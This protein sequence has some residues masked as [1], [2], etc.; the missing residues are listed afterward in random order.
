[1]APSALRNSSTELKQYRPKPSSYSHGL[2]SRAKKHLLNRNTK[3]SPLLVISG[4]GNYYV[5]GGGR[6]VYDATGGA[7]VS[8]IGR[9]DVRVENAIISQMRLGTAY[10]PSL[11]FYTNVTEEL[12]QYL[13]DSTG[14]RMSQAVFYGS[15]LVHLCPM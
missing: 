12:A 11:G 2:V 7:A 9:Y 6:A 5:L 1:M 4:Y 8:C 13:I 3:R 14:G 10:V 15:G